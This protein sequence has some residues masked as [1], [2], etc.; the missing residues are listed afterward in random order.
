MTSFDPRPVFAVSHAEFG[1][2]LGLPA[3]YEWNERTRELARWA[4]E[5][6][7]AHGRPWVFTRRAATLAW[8]GAR[9]AVDGVSLRGPALQKRLRDARATGALLVAI[10]AGPEAEAEARA[11]WLADK[12]DEYFFLE[13]Y[14]SAVVEALA[15][16]V[17]ARLCAEAEA[18][19]EVVLPHYSPGYPGWEL[20]DQP[21]LVELIRRSDWPAEVKLDVL[22]TGQLAP[23][24]SLAG[25]FPIAPKSARVLSAAELIPCEAC[26]FAPCDFRRAPY[27]PTA[28]PKGE[29][30]GP[31]PG[32]P[33]AGG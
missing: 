13:V 5:W 6:F 11:R 3:G 12:P 9:V 28:A 31:E 26:V 15:V 1:R 17:G 22:P 14:A 10:S 24:K 30:A 19:G 32:A 18:R 8:D 7:A 25:L 4:R 16:A 2:L 33:A 29:V 27:R 23:K 20:A 21:A